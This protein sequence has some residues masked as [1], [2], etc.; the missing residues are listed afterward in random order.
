MGSTNFVV[1]PKWKAP[2]VRDTYIKYFVAKNHT[3]GE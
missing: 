2:V 1:D 3:F